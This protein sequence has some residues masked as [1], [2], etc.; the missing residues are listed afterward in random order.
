M[1]IH[2]SYLINFN[3]VVEYTYEWVKIINGD[4]LNISKVNRSEIRRKILEIECDGHGEF[5]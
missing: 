5:K 1:N 2:K 4:I 3:Y